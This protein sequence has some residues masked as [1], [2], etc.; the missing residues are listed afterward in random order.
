LIFG[1]ALLKLFHGYLYFDDAIIKNA[2]G[3]LNFPHGLFLKAD[4]IF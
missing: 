3:F 1:G 4:V 2:E